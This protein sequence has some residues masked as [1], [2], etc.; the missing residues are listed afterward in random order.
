MEESGCLSVIA[1]TR[2]RLGACTLVE[3]ATDAFHAGV[4]EV[5][6]TNSVPHS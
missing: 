2:V 3:L 1:E 4:L 6:D 5:Q